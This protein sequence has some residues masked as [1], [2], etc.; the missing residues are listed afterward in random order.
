MNRFFNI[1][2]KVTEFADKLFLNN[3]FLAKFSLVNEDLKNIK[4]DNEKDCFWNETYNKYEKYEGDKLVKRHETLYKNGEKVKDEKYEAPSVSNKTNTKDNKL[5]SCCSDSNEN[6]CNCNCGGNCKCKGTQERYSGVEE[7][8]NEETVQRG[9]ED[10][11]RRGTQQLYD[12]NTSL[13]EENTKLL[14]NI[15]ELKEEVVK[16]QN[17]LENINGYITLYQE[18]LKEQNDKI[19]E[20]VEKL[21]KYQEIEN[22]IKQIRK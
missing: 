7:S 16:Y 15:N 3:D 12:E 18:T 5:S 1:E 9:F 20:L 21:E 13:K 14:L 11:V 22:I 19:Q 10:I 6:G 17:E 8:V 4:D 2:N